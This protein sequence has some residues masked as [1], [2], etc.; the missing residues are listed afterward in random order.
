[1]FADFIGW[2]GVVIGIFV[3]V[4]QLCKSLKEKSTQ[5]LSKHTYQLLLLTITCYLIKAI[6]IKE[7]V[8]IVSNSIGFVITATTLYLFRKY[9]SIATE[10]CRCPVLYF[11]LISRIL[12]VLY[13]GVSHEMG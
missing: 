7:T 10:P 13:R 3:A 9:P 6:A 4:P 5:G 2:T 1:M 11:Y 8:F 12:M